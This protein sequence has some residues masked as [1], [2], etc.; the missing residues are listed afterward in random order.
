LTEEREMMTAIAATLTATLLI[1][2]SVYCL[3][4]FC[5]MENKS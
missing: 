4:L 5:P 2:A 1:Y 3:A